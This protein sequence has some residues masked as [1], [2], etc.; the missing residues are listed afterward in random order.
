MLTTDPGKAGRTMF[1]AIGAAMEKRA[2]PL[3]Q[4]KTGGRC[5]RH[6]PPGVGG[7]CCRDPVRDFG[8]PAPEPSA[9]RPSAGATCIS[10]LSPEK[11]ECQPYLWSDIRAV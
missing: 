10:F 4:N 7:V 5:Q 3:P 1:V 11:K 6:P 9:N 8:V 2:R